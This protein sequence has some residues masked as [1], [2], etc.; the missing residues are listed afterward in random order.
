MDLDQ[1]LLVLAH[2]QDPLLTD[3]CRMDRVRADLLQ[4]LGGAMPTGLSEEVSIAV[5]AWLKGQRDA[6]SSFYEQ[7]LHRLIVR[8]AGGQLR[9]T[10]RPQS[11]RAT[12]AYYTGEAVVRYMSLQARNYVPGAV[13]VID[14]ACGA[15]ALLEGVE[16]EYGAGCLRLVGLD[17]DPLALELCRRQLP[18]AELHI[19]DALLDPV[20]GSYDLCLGNPPYISSGLR[21][22]APQDAAKATR[23]RERFPATAQY[24]L[25]TYPLF[26]ER[27]LEL[28]RTEGVLGFI[29]PDSFLT[30]RY[31]KG[32]RQLLLNQTLLELTLIQGEFWE[33]G[34]VGQS[35]ILFVRKGAAP[36]GHKV[37]IKVCADVRSLND[38]PAFTV[39]LT[40]LVWSSSQRF[41]L[42]ADPAIQVTVATMEAAG[43]APLGSLVR[44]Y[45]GLIGRKGQA[46]L[47]RSTNPGLSGPWAPL[48]RSGGEIDRYRLAWAG[49]EVCL[50]P[51]LIKSGGRRAHYEGPKLLLRQ[52]ADALRAVYDEQ[53]YY[54]LNNI[55]LLVARRSDLDLRV[56]LGV[57]N[58]SAVGVYYRAVAMEQGR[59]YAQVDLDLLECLPV[60]AILPAEHGRLRA[61]V[62][63]RQNAASAEAAS[64][65]G[66]IDQVV[67]GL[68]GLPDRSRGR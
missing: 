65:E 43:V 47:L 51:D 59:L 36:V 24:K 1:V 14:P 68:Y 50:Q 61:L 57:I 37:A 62:Q 12:G 2:L 27:G 64:L 30:G 48:L 25:N 18:E 35:V 17:S 55:H 40:D 52:T 31:F 4:V 7:T 49:E 13:S 56:M 63:Q 32:L 54:C 9:M 33:N 11:H 34:R 20:V 19:L 22:S 26:V 60:P 16:R 29:L 6:H 45:S 23:L 38:A 44:S 67:N 66:Q 5:R 42:I 10:Q 21:G 46:S 53:G 15:G 8:A 3:E 41:R 39:P 58:S 28:L